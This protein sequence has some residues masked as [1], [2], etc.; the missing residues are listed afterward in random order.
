[1]RINGKII[2]HNDCTWC[3]H[4]VVYKSNKSSGELEKCKLTWN[5]IKNPQDRGRRY[6]E[7]YQQ[8]NCDCE[9]CNTDIP[10]VTY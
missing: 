9:K 7:H 4:R 2:H 6:C 1:M 8:K 10:V 5:D 3:N